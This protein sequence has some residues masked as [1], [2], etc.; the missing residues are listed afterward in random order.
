M[1]W[2]FT[3][4][5]LSRAALGRAGERRA[6]IYYRLRGYSVVGANI[7]LPAGEI[8]LAVRRGKLLVIVEVKT[9]QSDSGGEA[10]ERVDREKRLR[11]VRLAEQLVTSRSDLR[12]LQIR[13]DILS[14]RYTGWWF[15]IRQ[16]ADAFRPV[17]DARRPWQWTV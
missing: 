6:R 17:A 7:H 5:R 1:K 9:R 2:L 15:V 8:D 3:P 16:L 11:L 14:I 12:G 4:R 10:W 13:Y